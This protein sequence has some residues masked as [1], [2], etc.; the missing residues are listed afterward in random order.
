MYSKTTPELSYV[1]GA[2]LG[3]GHLEKT[4][5]LA[6]HQTGLPSYTYRLSLIVTDREFAE[7]FA[8]SCGKVLKRPDSTNRTINIY[9]RGATFKL[10]SIK[11]RFQVCP[12]SRSFGDWFTGLTEEEL[13]KFALIEPRNYLRAL[14][15]SDGNL[16]MP[17]GHPLVRI[18]K[19][20][21]KL[22]ALRIA[23]SCLGALGINHRLA[24]ARHAGQST[25]LGISNQD[26]YLL[27]PKPVRKF[28]AEVG[29]S[30]PRKRLE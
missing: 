9:C 30:I 13:T 21:S 3:D 2:L 18:F 27:S 23:I 29:S 14:Y 24:I 4:K 11:P 8:Y 1:I 28:L 10:N 20:Q 5:P 22:R 25:N 19:P 26:L 15:D 6:H 16:S 7:R 12:A 17:N